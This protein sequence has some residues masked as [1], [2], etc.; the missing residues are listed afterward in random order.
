MYY[1]F[2]PIRAFRGAVLVPRILTR[3]FS[4]ASRMVILV[5]DRWLAPFLE[6]SRA[7]LFCE[8][9]RLCLDRGQVEFY[10]TL[11][12]WRAFKTMYHLGTLG[13]L[14]RKK[15]PRMLT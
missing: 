12:S 10:P 1:V 15:S 14:G 9:F 2:V 8:K 6:Y 7:R 3:L 4:K 11:I 5:P 13:T